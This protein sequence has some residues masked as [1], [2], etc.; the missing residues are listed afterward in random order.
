MNVA[1]ALRIDEVNLA[2]LQQVLGSYFG[3]S[4][5]D[6]SEPDVVWYGPSPDDRL[7]GLRFDRHDRVEPVQGPALREADVASIGEIVRS[8]LVEDQG[9]AIAQTVM[10]AS[11]PVTS[12]WKYGNMFQ[13][14]PVP[15]EAPRPREMV[16]QHPFLLEVAIPQSQD[17]VINSHRRERQTQEVSLVLGALM[18]PFV[19]APDSY[20]RKYWVLDRKDKAD[21]KSP[22]VSLWGQQGYTWEGAR[23]IYDE[24][25]DLSELD[26]MASVAS[27]DYYLR[28]GIE[29]RQVLEIS[30]SLQ[31]SL[32][33]FFG[34]DPLDRARYLRAAYWFRHSHLVHDLSRSAALAALVHSVESLLEDVEPE[35]VC[36][37]CGKSKEMGPTGLFKE[38]VDD[39]APSVLRLG[40]RDLYRARS[41][42]VH[43]N[44]LLRSDTELFGW[45]SPTLIAE[46][47]LSGEAHLVAR[48]VLVNSLV[49]GTVSKG[50]VP[51]V[52]RGTMRAVSKRVEGED[53]ASNEK[54]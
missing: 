50:A 13:V 21:E 1:E 6:P 51:L 45:L 38:L 10:F 27:D 24:F 25:S 39:L 12:Y 8:A 29:T 30:D 40:R 14:L 4:H 42:I 48:A 49:P 54:G 53:P 44:R 9:V 23:G 15:P 17:W 2:E 36:S 33:A 28:R 20:H 16:A 11:V 5:I 22:L 34:R 46:W 3:H 18:T 7:L 32:D 41:K 31:V 52:G 37:E 47:N 26:V 19:H 35:G 43:G